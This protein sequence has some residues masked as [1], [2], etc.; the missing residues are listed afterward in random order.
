MFDRF[1]CP[2]QGPQALAS[3]VAPTRSKAAIWPSRSTVARTC[4]DPG[5]TSSGVFTRSPADA[6]CRA[7]LAARL[8][9]SYELLV[10]EP[11]SASLISSG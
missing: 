8:M 2:M 3:T 9:S 1:H 6:A 5:V 4:S 7:R 11:I 10:H